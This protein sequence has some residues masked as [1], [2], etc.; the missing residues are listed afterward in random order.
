[1]EDDEAADALAGELSELVI[2]LSQGIHL[3]D[4]D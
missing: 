3:I 1:M 4:E 2:N